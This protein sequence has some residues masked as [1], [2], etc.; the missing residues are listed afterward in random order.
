MQRLYTAVDAFNHDLQGAGAWV[1]AGGL[2]P[3]ENAKVA[4]ASSTPVRVTD[5]P[6]SE[7]KE[8]IGGFWIIEAETFADA[9]DWAA[10]G[11]RACEGPVEVR[12]FQ[13]VPE[14]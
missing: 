6:F 13:P 3:V 9:L 7:A 10:K 12:A 14:S 1:F 8:Y 5:G 4:D 11:S 2:E